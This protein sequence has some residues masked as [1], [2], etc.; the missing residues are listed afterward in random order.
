MPLL[1]DNADIRQV[2]KMPELIAE[3]RLAFTDYHQHQ[4]IVRV[5]SDTGIPRPDQ[6]ANYVFKSME[7]GYVRRGVYAIRMSSDILTWPDRAGGQRKEKLP[8]HPG[9]RY[10]GLILLFSIDSGELLAV[11]PDGEIQK[12]RV[13]ATNGVGID[14]MA[15]QDA[16]SVGLIGVGNQAGPHLLAACA[17]RNVREVWVYSPTPAR[18]EAF[19]ES[20]QAQLGIPVH[21]VDSAEVAV[22]GR[23]LVLCATN[24]MAPVLASDWIQPGCHVSSL[25]RFELPTELLVRA[26]RLAIHTQSWEPDMQLMGQAQLPDAQLWQERLQEHGKSWLQAPEIGAL[27]SGEV[28]GRAD[29]AELTCFMNNIGTGLQF[30]ASAYLVLNKA[31]DAGLGQTL[32]NDW[33]TQIEVT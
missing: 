18:R 31:R 33:F 12:M 23:D 29:A 21:A 4:G 15:R 19:A 26:D 27:T 5:R 8:S 9:G 17:V 3:L 13:G 7:G 24:A 32:P 2:L 1:L 28:V 14:C 20:W 6:A 11:M 30:A 22:R 16:T 10:L 25:K